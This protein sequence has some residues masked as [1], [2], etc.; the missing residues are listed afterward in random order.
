MDSLSPDM[1]SQ[2]QHRTVKR[3]IL[4]MNQRYMAEVAVDRAS[5]QAAD[6]RDDVLSVDQICLM[7]MVGGWL[8]GVSPT[9]MDEF[10]H[11]RLGTSQAR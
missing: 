3:L 10:I 2:Q 5:E 6:E 9:A 4:S 11:T 1:V 8:D 7:D